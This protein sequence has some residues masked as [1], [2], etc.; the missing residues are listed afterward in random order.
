MNWYLAKMVY[1]IIC[2]D[3]SHTPQ[4][5]EQ[6]RLIFAHDEFHAFQ[7]AQLIGEREQDLFL[8]AVQ[9]PVKWKFID[10]SELHKLDDLIDGAE[11]YS[12]ICE[13]EDAE[14]FIGLTHS[15]AA[16]ILESSMNKSLYLN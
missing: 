8:N 1:Q 16:H 11:M 7:K 14:A 9:K 13:E 5:D 6:L 12:K 4:F 2:G 15:R 10:V 3:G